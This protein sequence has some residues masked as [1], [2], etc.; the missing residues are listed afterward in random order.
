M[1]F[2]TYR[3]QHFSFSL[4]D[5]CLL[6]SLDPQLNLLIEGRIH[7]YVFLWC[8]PVSNSILI[9]FSLEQLKKERNKIISL[10]KCSVNEV[11][12]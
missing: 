2:Y 11:P 8:F 3:D 5:L 4:S 9:L 12:T 1:P 6:I 7:S 10:L